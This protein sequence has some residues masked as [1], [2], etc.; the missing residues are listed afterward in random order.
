MYGSAHLDTQL[1]DPWPVPDNVGPNH[2]PVGCS[3]LLNASPPPA[4][5]NGI[6]GSLGRG[7]QAM[8]RRFSNSAHSTIPGVT[9]SAI[10]GPV[11]FG[12]PIGIGQKGR[13]ASM[14]SSVG[15]GSVGKEKSGWLSGNPFSHNTNTNNN[16]GSGGGAGGGSM[17]KTS[18]IFND[19]NPFRSTATKPGQDVFTADPSDETLA[20]SE[21]EGAATPAPGMARRESAIR[22]GTC[23]HRP[24][25][26]RRQ[27]SIALGVAARRGLLMEGQ[28]QPY[29]SK[30]NN[31]PG[32]AQRAGADGSASG[33]IQPPRRNSTGPGTASGKEEKGDDIE[34]KFRAYQQSA[35]KDHTEADLHPM[36]SFWHKVLH[37]SDTSH[38][39]PTPPSLSEGAGRR[40]SAPIISTRANARAAAS[41]PSV[42]P[43]ASPRSSPITG[44]TSTIPSS[45]MTGTGSLAGIGGQLEAV[46]EQEGEERVRSNGSRTGTPVSGT[47][48]GSS[49]PKSASSDRLND[50]VKGV[51]LSEM[52]GRPGSPGTLGFEG[53]PTRNSPNRS[54]AQSSS[55]TASL[56]AAIRGTDSPS[57][58]TAQ[59][60]GHMRKGS[61]EEW[62][63]A[64]AHST[65]ASLQSSQGAGGIPD[66]AKGSSDGRAVRAR[67]HI[68]LN[69]TDHSATSSVSTSGSE[70][71]GTGIT[72]DHVKD[73]NATLRHPDPTIRA[74]SPPP[75]AASVPASAQE[76]SEAGEEEEETSREH[77]YKAARGPDTPSTTSG[78][79]SP[80]T[81]ITPNSAPYAE[82]GAFGQTDDSQ[83]PRGDRR[84]QESPLPRRR[85][86]D[87]A[88]NNDGQMNKDRPSERN[89]AVLGFHSKMAGVGKGFMSGF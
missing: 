27:N 24:P 53:V 89:H 22:F 33:S 11:D 26:L 69:D 45:S 50:Q 60:G 56:T 74:P 68:S 49:T 38:P 7:F 81:P 82:H 76:R 78:R 5:A 18:G 66:P 57:S 79:D 85:A 39:N 86:S 30:W 80:I 51:R 34:A 40:A 23:P 28:V 58:Q 62:S 15:G 20:T 16:A 72:H 77:L 41:S 36:K 12:V 6:S 29:G 52:Y 14:S 65:P 83:P 71:L 4:D 37:P 48:K 31:S 42:S 32:A 44:N 17:E 2:C 10:G 47:P 64:P 87:A 9:P 73:G 67:D 3:I 84:Y 61:Y 8:K 35:P 63:H 21:R 1:H 54:P 19:V 25:E 70:Q 88:Y 55:S 59:K 13:S 43:I 75:P 46:K